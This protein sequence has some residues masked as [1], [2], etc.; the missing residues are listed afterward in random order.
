MALSIR[1]P[2]F[3]VFCYSYWDLC[4]SGES[5]LSLQ[6]MIRRSQR[7]PSRGTIPE[8]DD[9][10]CASVPCRVAEIYVICLCSIFNSWLVVVQ[11][12]TRKSL[13][14]DKNE[15]QTPHC[16]LLGLLLC[17]GHLL[18]ELGPNVCCLNKARAYLKNRLRSSLN[19]C[20]GRGAVSQSLCDERGGEY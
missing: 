12:G 19:T 20:H 3:F 13:H 14:V 2:R 4:G 8:F 18:M 5:K 15:W 9:L 7:G 11:R 1:F 16:Q 10:V 6:P 17:G